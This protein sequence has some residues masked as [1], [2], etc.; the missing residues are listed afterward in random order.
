MFSVQTGRAVDS[1]STLAG[2]GIGRDMRRTLRSGDGKVEKGIMKLE[3]WK[4]AINFTADEGYRTTVERQDISCGF[5]EIVDSKKK[6]EN[7]C[8]Y[9]PVDPRKSFCTNYWHRI[10]I[11]RRRKIGEYVLANVKVFSVRNIRKAIERSGVLTEEELKV[12]NGEGE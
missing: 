12:F 9:C 5:C 8:S 4:D 6:T 10:E 1:C 2:T 11:D 3:T 7:R